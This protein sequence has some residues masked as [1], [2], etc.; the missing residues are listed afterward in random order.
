MSDDDDL[1]EREMASLGLGPDS[2]AIRDRE[3]DLFTEALKVSKG[4][5]TTTERP[6]TA[7]SAPARPSAVETKD[8]AAR[9]F[10]EAMGALWKDQAPGATAPEEIGERLE[11]EPVETP[12]PPR[13]AVESDTEAGRIFE[14]ALR[15]LSET[16]H[17][18]ADDPVQPE[19]RDLWAEPTQSLRRMIQKGRLRHDSELDL[20]GMTQREARSAVE[21]YLAN[22]S[23]GATRLVR[24]ICGRGLHSREGSVLLRDTLPTW[25]QVD[26]QEWVERSWRA[27]RELGGEGAWYAVLRE[28]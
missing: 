26:F 9:I 8:E 1:F 7:A 24:I 16:P 5:E 6:E 17:K 18:E 3:D 25:L 11:P 15:D 4:Q 19:P 2:R 14:E 28:T 23:G 27:P 13:R 12:P 10:E 21:S 20:H 22:S